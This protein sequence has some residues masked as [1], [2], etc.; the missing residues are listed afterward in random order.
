MRLCL[1]DSKKEREEDETLEWLNAQVRWHW[2]I[3]IILANALCYV[4]YLPQLVVKLLN[5]F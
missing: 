4:V 1:Q 3:N 2:S 5:D